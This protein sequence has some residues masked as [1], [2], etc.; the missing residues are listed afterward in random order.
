MTLKN[1]SLNPAAPETKADPL[2]GL[3]EKELLEL[4][5]RIDSKLKV[6]LSRIN[7]AEELGLQ[8]RSGMAM[9]LEV[10]GDKDVPANQKSQVFNSVSKMLQDIIKQQKIVFSAER[11]KRFE[12]AFLKV[13]Q[14]L[15]PAQTRTYFDL[16]GE[17]LQ[18]NP[19]ALGVL[20][21]IAPGVTSGQ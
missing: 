19:D 2:E 9:M 5:T 13:L 16:Y 15:P 1:H 6:D 20:E 7:L 21:Q 10:Q 11:M 4:R 14:Q 8:Y 17:F 18:E 12:A 3:S